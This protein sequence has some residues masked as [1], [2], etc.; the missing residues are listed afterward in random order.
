MHDCYIYLRVNLWLLSLSLI[1]LGETKNPIA[2][3]ITYITGEPIRGKYKAI[4]KV[5]FEYYHKLEKKLQEYFKKYHY[6]LEE[7]EENKAGGSEYYYN[8]IENLIEYYFITN[9]IKYEKLTEEELIKIDSTTFKIY[10]SLQKKNIPILEENAEKELEYINEQENKQ[11]NEQ[12]NE[13]EYKNQ[14]QNELEYKNELEYI[15]EQENKQENEQENEQEYKNQ[16][17]NELEYKNELEYIEYFDDI[18]DNDLDTEIIQDIQNYLDKEAL[19]NTE[20]KTENN[21]ENK[22]EL[23]LRQ[24]QQEVLDKIEHYYNN[25]TAG[26]IIWACGLGKALLS[27]LIAK[28]LK[29][30]T[31]VFGV[32]TIRLQSQIMKEIR[33][34]YNNVNVLLCGGNPNNQSEFNINKLKKLQQE[35][36]VLF[37]I[38]TYNSCNKLVDNNLSFDFKIGDE[39]HRL[40]GSGETKNKDKNISRRQ[41]HKINTTKSL[42][43]TAT[44][45]NSDNQNIISMNKKEIFGEVIDFKSFAWAIENKMITDYKILV[46]KNT[47]EEVKHMIET[48]TESIDKDLYMSC[49]M[50]LKSMEIYPDLTHVLLYTNTDEHA[51]KCHVYI[52]TLLNS[53]KFIFDTNK[54][55]NKALTSKNTDNGKLNID[56]EVDKFKNTPLGIIPCVHIF[57][58]GFNLEKLNGVCIADKMESKIRIIQSLLR[59]NR[60]DKDNPDKIAYVILPYIG[61]WGDDNKFKKVK[62]ILSE[63]DEEDKKLEDKV[64]VL[65]HSRKNKKQTGTLDYV[66]YKDTSELYKLKIHALKRGIKFTHNVEKYQYLLCQLKNEE[67]NIQSIEEYINSKDHRSSESFM[68]DPEKYFREKGLWVNWYDFLKIDTTHLIKSLRELKEFCKSKNINEHNYHDEIKKYPQIPK[69]PGELINNFTSFYDLLASRTRR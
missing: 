5:D 44:E 41:F 64:I 46:I 59:P 48:L 55:Y 49:Y 16:I 27:I 50:C 33:R 14:I 13:Q 30:K 54:F 19:D 12:E 63:L 31:V 18:D 47:I 65:K 10:N 32:P 34:V 66:L 2:R 15:N 40:T 61:E 8:H 62:I 3:N 17:Q 21:T 36:K 23:I 35:D 53:G 9:N 42:Y 29:F 20:N 45:K 7:K 22:T 37:I 26:K 38:T 4:Y 51:Q 24:H 6:I 43:M 58:E 52:K 28:T 57:S 67:L 39:A 69:M 1:K 68:L 25:N 60:L 11:E 56:A